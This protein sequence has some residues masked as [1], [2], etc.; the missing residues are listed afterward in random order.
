MTRTSVVTLLIA[1]GLTLGLAAT[2]VPAAAQ[3]VGV[4]VIYVDADAAG[5][6]NGSSW[7]DAYTD[8]Q[9]VLGAAAS[10]NQPIAGR[11]KCKLRRI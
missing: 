5:A 11:P 1:V 7:T 4:S 6:S 9:D 2:A 10:T 3:P 8:L